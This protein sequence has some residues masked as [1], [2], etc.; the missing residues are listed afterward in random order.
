[1]STVAQATFDILRARGLT[2]IFGNP[3]SNELKFLAAMPP[4]F[5]YV[6]GLHEGAVISMADG[7]ALA[8]GGPVLVNLHAASGSGNAMGGLTN[9]VY[10]HSPLIVTAGQQVRS[11]I[12][13][14][15]MLANVGAAELAKPLV[16]WSSEPAC[17][18]DVPRTIDQA[19]HTAVTAPRGPVYVSVPY[20]DWDAPAD[21]QSAHLPGRR[22]RTAGS[23]APDQLAELVELL[24]AATNPVLVLG[25]QVDA[26]EANE[27]AVRLAESLRAPVWIAP[28]ASRCPF[29][30]RH[31]AFRGVLPAA[32]QPL[33]DRLTGHDVVLV[34]GAPVFRYHQHVPGTYL[35]EGTRLVQL[36]AD[37]G[38]AARAPIGDSL[39]T[40]V[41][42]AL[43]QLA[44]AVPVADRPPLP[45]LP[46]FPQPRTG[47]GF[48]HPDE[49]FALLREHA[50]AD[51]VYVTES[52]STA[53]SFWAQMDLT[54]P[55]SYYFPASGGL[56][57]GLPAAVG[58]QLARP[59]RQV[60]GLIGDGSANYGITALWTAARYRVP[61]VFVILK[62]GTYGALRWF[63][64]LLDTGET[65]GLDVPGI[66]FVQLAQGYGVEARAVTTGE[67]FVLA[68]KSALG[69]TGP[70]LIEVATADLESANTA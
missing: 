27:N 19:V 20:D 1:M 32:V 25:P 14:E 51:A 29:P 63:A 70:V 23:L 68:L 58:A 61:V 28:S 5:T 38:E 36:T 60:I 59:E 41:N 52:T 8:S 37:P 44:A 47:T 33:A 18:E 17:A 50:P 65:P 7:F 69:Q 10:S 13:Q 21:P 30:T 67:E 3:G 45:P 40:D 35:P 55:G 22:V 49:V 34:V 39:V 4:D 53:D 43:A 62:N 64:D 26:A 12:G 15:V 2:T 31:P 66:N 54:R 42:G 46:D 16:K 11:T 24:A 48:V 57:F 56:G 6:L 9:A